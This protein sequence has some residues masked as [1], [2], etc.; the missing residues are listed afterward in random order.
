MVAFLICRKSSL[1]AGFDRTDALRE[2]EGS[3]TYL[4]SPRDSIAM[5]GDYLTKPTWKRC[6]FTKLTEMSMC[7]EKCF[8]RDVAGRLDLA[9]P[10]IRGADCQVLKSGDQFSKGR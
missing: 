8:L 1:G 9:E 3:N 4:P 10:G 2:L 5:F 7:L 6:R